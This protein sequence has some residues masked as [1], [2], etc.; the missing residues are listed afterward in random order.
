MRLKYL[1]SVIVAGALLVGKVVAQGGVGVKET[2]KADYAYNTNS[3]YAAIELYEKAQKKVKDKKVKANIQYHIAKCY[4]KINNHKKAESFFKKVKVDP[5]DPMFHYDYGVLLKGG[6]RYEEAKVQFEKYV[7][8]N[9]SDYKGKAQVESCDLAI[10]WKNNPTC[11]RVENFKDINTKEWDFAPMI[12]NKKGTQ[13]IFSSNRK[14]STGKPNPIWGFLNEDLYVTDQEKSSSRGSGGNKWKDPVFL[15]G[16]S[17]TFSEGSGTM[18]RKYSTIY[19]TRCMGGDKK[20]GTGCQIYSSRRQGPTKWNDAVKLELA[21]DTFVTGHPTLT[22]DGN[23][24]IFASNM[25]GGEGGMDLYIAAYNKKQKTYVDPK[26]LNKDINTFFEEMYPYVKDDWTLYFSSNRP[27]GM[28]GLDIFQSKLIGD[29]KNNPDWD[30][31]KNMK[32]PINSNGDDFGIVFEPGKEAGYLTSDRKGTKG[33]DDIWKFSIPPVKLV[34]SGTV[35]DKDTKEVIP[36]ATVELKDAAGN[37]FKTT[38]DATGFY[39][40]E[41]PFGVAYDMT[42][43]KVDY[44]NDVAHATTMG[45]DPLTTCRDTNIVRDFYLKTQKIE[46]EFEVQFKFDKAE[47]FPEYND[48]LKKIVVIMTDNPT[49]VAEVGAHTDARGG[50]KY[51]EELATRR[52]NAIV[53]YLV[54]QGINEKRLVPKGYGESEPR[55][56]HMDMKGAESG[57]IFPAGTE[58]TEEYINALKKEENGEKKFEDAHR[59]NRRVTVKKVSND[60]KPPVVKEEDDDNNGQ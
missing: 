55:K 8:K 47:W 43:S 25:P 52:A 50:D 11:Y 7:Q 54:E 17:T 5:D 40:E 53:K 22:P 23:F 58:L 31:P 39:K 57:F 32:Y 60:F 30:K 14:K 20:S 56:L 27:E 3:F 48:T 28:G 19:F 37:V 34:L 59:L 42:A 29:D 21:P 13:L 38:T 16:L 4:L 45:L 49:L 15:P 36:G 46:L 26:P 12:G 41:I 10:Q 18:D 2:N 44:Y 24:M 1:F 6:E 33:Y 9:P 35:R 51:N